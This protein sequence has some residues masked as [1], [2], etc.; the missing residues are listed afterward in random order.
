MGVRRNFRCKG[1]VPP[2]LCIENIDWLAQDD[3]ISMH[4]H[5]GVHK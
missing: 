2:V 5:T 1:L 4:A 3:N